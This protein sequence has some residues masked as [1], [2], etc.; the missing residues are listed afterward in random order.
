VPGG[1]ISLMLLSAIISIRT[2]V[3]HSI[4]SMPSL[5][6]K[7]AQIILVVYFIIQTW[8]GDRNKYQSPTVLHASQSASSIISV[9]VDE[10]VILIQLLKQLNMAAH[11]RSKERIWYIA[12]RSDHWP[13]M[14]FWGPDYF[15]DKQFRE[16]FRMSRPL[17]FRLHQ[18]LQ[19]FIEKQTT[20]FRV[21]VPSIH[22]LAIFSLPRVAWR[23]LSCDDAFIWCCH[24]YAEREFGD[25]I[26]RVVARATM[27]IV[28]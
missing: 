25:K 3:V 23:L 14:V 20:R 10:L 26:F 24:G 12:R 8:L 13:K 22:H 15:T 7:T 17:F 2:S 9:D 11:I 1:I 28:K 5:Q 16:G 19:P 27:M 4:T 18:L 21:P 6:P